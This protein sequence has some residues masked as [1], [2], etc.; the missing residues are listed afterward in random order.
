MYT[1][2]YDHPDQS[3][4]TRLLTIRQI[5]TPIE[6]FLTPDIAR[7]WTHPHLLSDMRRGVERIARAVRDGER[8]M[9]FGDYDVDGMTS[10]SILYLFVKHGL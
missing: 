7:D 2:L 1:I 9:I 4:L 5:T 6:D 10:S 3:L 8:I